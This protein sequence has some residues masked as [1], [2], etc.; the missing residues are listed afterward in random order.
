MLGGVRRDVS[1]GGPYPIIRRF[2]LTS[3]VP[4]AEVLVDV[5]R[6]GDLIQHAAAASPPSS[7]ASL[8]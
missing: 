3:P 8:H 5:L 4:C 1:D 2:G 6:I 7:P